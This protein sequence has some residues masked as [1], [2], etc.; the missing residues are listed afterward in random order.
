MA[1]EKVLGWEKCMKVERLWMIGAGATLASALAL[2]EA[3]GGDGGVDFEDPRERVLKLLPEQD[4]LLVNLDPSEMPA[5]TDMVRLGRRATQAIINGLVNSMSPEIRSSCAAVLTATRDPRALVALTDSLDDPHDGVRFL[6]L[7]ALGMVESRAA[8]PK[9]LSLMGKP[10]VAP[11]VAEQAV[12]TLGRTGDP[13]A[14]DPLLR[15]FRQSWDSA[16]QMALWDMRMQLDAGEIESIVVPPLEAAAEGKDVPF[17][18]VAFAVERAGDLELGSAVGPLQELFDAAPHLQNR[19]VYNLGRIGA[20]SAKGF[21]RSRVDRTGDARLLNNVMFA[22]QRLGDDITP[23]L[24]EALLDRRA[25]IRFNA[26]FVAGDL[27]EARVLDTLIAALED[28]NDVVRSEAAVALGRIGSAQAIGALETA[29]AGDNPIVR[30][31][32]LIA[33]ARIDYARYRDGVV[34]LLRSDDPAVRDKAARFLAEQRDPKLVGPVLSALSPMVWDDAS[35]A[36]E[37]LGRFESL[38]DADASAWLLRAG[39]GGPQSHGALVLLA[40]FA[41]ER[42]RFVLRQ[43]LSQPGGEQDELLRA[44]GRL[45]DADSTALAR[46]WFEQQNEL[47]SQLHAAYALASL[48]DAD[49]ASHLVRALEEGPAEMKRTVAKLLTEL[50]KDVLAGLAEPL[51]KLMGHEDVYVRLYAARV[52]TTRNDEAAFL[53]LET[54]LNKKVPFIRD[55]VLDIMERAPRSYAGP[56][57]ERWRAKA[58]PL[59]AEEL[60]RILGRT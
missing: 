33:L 19:I 24:R 45:R 16:A 4:D 36:L 2:A 20:S 48:A 29:S 56:V 41:D 32:A 47:V 37:F 7:Q 9:I 5:T 42:A 3:M 50:P 51:S 43:W 60:D 34:P 10:G 17:P 15:R 26:A 12:S 31:D 40:R 53:R 27:R 57:L 52:L 38:D 14:V 58:G 6:A 1:P 59:L 49:A 55:E 13:K 25:Y 22:L 30:R 35:V 23:Y 44:M 11:Y 39:A 18:V 21:L 28:A 54:E 46:R 8:T